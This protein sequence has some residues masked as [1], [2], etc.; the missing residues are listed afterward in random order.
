MTS[1]KKVIIIPFNKFFTMNQIIISNITD[2]E[3]KYRFCH[4]SNEVLRITIEDVAP[5]ENDTIPCQPIL[6]L[7]ENDSIIPLYNTK[8]IEAYQWCLS[9]TNR[10]PALYMKS[11]EFLLI[12]GGDGMK[13][14]RFVAKEKRNCVLMSVKLGL[15]IV[16]CVPY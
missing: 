3:S 2:I 16:I 11:E 15:K 7:F 10:T 5:I 8:L 6:C 14:K 4:N 9:I 13:Y 12:S 1:F